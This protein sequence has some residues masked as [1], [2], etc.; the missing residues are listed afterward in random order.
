MG[1]RE[2]GGE[3]RHAISPSC[4]V[5]RIGAARQRIGRASSIAVSRQSPAAPIALRVQGLPPCPRDPLLLRRSFRRRRSSRAG[6]AACS[7]IPS[8]VWSLM[9]GDDVLEGGCAA[10]AVLLPYERRTAVLLV[11]ATP[12]HL[13]S[14]W[15][16]QL[17]WPRSY[18]VAHAARPDDG[19][20]QR[21]E[22]LR[23]KQEQVGRALSARVHA[24]NAEARVSA[25]PVSAAVP[26]LRDHPT[27]TMRRLR[28]RRLG[29]PR[30]FR[31]RYG[32]EER[33]SAASIRSSRL[34]S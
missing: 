31:G 14:R 28:A 15:A 3:D 17:S 5:A 1:G 12:V 34:S 21:V 4:C 27:S 25:R 6:W 30:I 8:T 2:A 26:G 23:A 29:G 32:D 24:A 19:L 22:A 33:P 16:G 18:R 10:G 20:V 13:R 9:R 7:A 11:D